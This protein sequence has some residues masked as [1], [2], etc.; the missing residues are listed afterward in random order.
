VVD[1]GATRRVAIQFVKDHFDEVELCL[2]SDK[3]C[4]DIASASSWSASRTNTLR[5]TS[6]RCAIH[7]VDEYIELIGFDQATFKDLTTRQDVEETE[8]F[9]AHKDSSKYSLV[10]QQTLDSIR[11]NAAWIEV[12][13]DTAQRRRQTLT[14]VYAALKEGCRGLGTKSGLD[15]LLLSLHNTLPCRMESRMLRNVIWIITEE[16]E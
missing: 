10:L 2:S 1:N 11:A 6:W 15:Q 3:L 13:T 14:L 5:C 16:S 7:V 9:F 12:C 8:A 4:T